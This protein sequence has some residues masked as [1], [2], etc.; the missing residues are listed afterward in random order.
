MK[1]PEIPGNVGWMS[2]EEKLLA[3]IILDDEVAARL[4]DRG[5]EAFFR[6]FIV[7]NRATGQIMM[8]HRF[9]YVDHDAWFEVDP[10]EQEGALT[11]LRES[12]TDMLLTAAQMMDGTISP[13]AVQVF[14]PPDDEGD[15][16]ST[17]AWLSARDLITVTRVE[18]IEP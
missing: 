4:T 7:Q 16:E 18:V 15:F 1:N 17:I 2:N 10:K 8:R 14:E 6:A 9:R 3:L 5:G 12:L 11:Y 13:L